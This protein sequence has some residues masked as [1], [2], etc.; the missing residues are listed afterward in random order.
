MDLDIMNEP[1]GA[2]MEKSKII[3]NLGDK[4]W[5]LTKLTN[6]WLDRTSCL[7]DYWNEIKY[8]YIYMYICVI[9]RAC[10]TVLM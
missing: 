6:A 1:M 4:E 10:A 7:L 2:S 5:H 3:N 8:I 9:R